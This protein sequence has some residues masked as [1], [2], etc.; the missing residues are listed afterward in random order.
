MIGKSIPLTFAVILTSIRTSVGCLLRP[1]QRTTSIRGASIMESRDTICN[2]P[3]EVHS[4]FWGNQFPKRVDIP[5]VLNDIAVVL[6]QHIS[7]AVSHIF[8]GTSSVPEFR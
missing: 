8:G 4:P 5:L 6:I 2:E 3:D 1:I 7:A